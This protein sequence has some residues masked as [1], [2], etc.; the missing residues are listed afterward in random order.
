[1]GFTCHYWKPPLT[2]LSETFPSPPASEVVWQ[3]IGITPADRAGLLLQKPCC[4]WITGLSGS[5]KSTLA[6]ALDCALY[7]RGIKSF[8]LDGDNVRHGLSKDLGM[9]EADRSENI[10]RVGEVAKLLLDAGLLVI[11]AFISPYKRDRQMVRSLFAQGDF[12]E[13]HLDTPISVCETRDVKGLYKKARQGI[14]KNFTGVS[15]PYEA[16]DA[17]EVVLNT[18]NTC[19][20]ES[21]EKILSILAIP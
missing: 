12:L 3:S 9:S 6:N 18:S 10:R 8:L 13:I 5:G 17:A 16:P 21:V 19:V 2:D 4:I 11:C 1:L 15:D 14:L 7:K 20:N